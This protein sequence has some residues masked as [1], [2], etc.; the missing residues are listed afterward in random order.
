MPPVLGGAPV[1]PAPMAR[2]VVEKVAPLRSAGRAALLMVVRSMVVV[3]V[4]VVVLMCC[5]VVVL[6]EGKCG[7]FQ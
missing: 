5:G 2:D 7:S 3:M 4:V 6:E 1:S